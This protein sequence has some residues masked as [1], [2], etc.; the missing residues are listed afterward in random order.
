MVAEWSTDRSSPRRGY[1]PDDEHLFSGAALIRLQE[2]Q[3]DL[4]WLLDRGYAKTGALDLVSRHY[5]LTARQSM[6]LQRCSDAAS[7]CLD[8]RAKQQD[9]ALLPGAD[10]AIDGLNLIILLEVALSKSPVF[11]GRD[12]VL[13]DLAGLRG[14]YHL[15]PQTARA[16]DLVL[17][18]LDHGS[19]AKA[20]IF[21]DAPVSNS[22]R[23]KTRILEQAGSFM[24]PVEVELVRNADVSLEGCTHVVS[25]DAVVLDRCTSWFNLARFILE[26]HVPEAWIVRLDGSA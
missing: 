21:L 12:G 4:L 23:L 11:L 13:R 8:R 5:Q 19:V 3:T 20:H 17:A 9:L 1:D 16:I 26:T 14:T 6:A 15:I 22:G 7:R 25:G 18:A 24:T 10:L 2:A